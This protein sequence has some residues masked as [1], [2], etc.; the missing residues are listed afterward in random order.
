METRRGVIMREQNLRSSVRNIAGVT[1]SSSEPNTIWRLGRKCTP[2]LF[3][4]AVR[5]I[6][7]AFCLT[8][9]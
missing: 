8:G 7:R 9:W 6:I 1:R 2:E 5:L 4:F 3:S